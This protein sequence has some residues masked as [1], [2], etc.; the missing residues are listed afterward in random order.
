MSGRRLTWCRRAPG[1]AS[2]CRSSA[3]C[4]LGINWIVGSHWLAAVADLSGESGTDL[5]RSGSIRTVGWILSFTVFLISLPA[6]IVFFPFFLW[7]WNLNY[8]S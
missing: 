7:K 4:F 3:L 1:T 8:I 2:R 5:V 6:R